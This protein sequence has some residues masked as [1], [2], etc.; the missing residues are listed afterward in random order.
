M[1]IKPFGS[2]LLIKPVD[3]K[4]YVTDSGIEVINNQ[5]KVGEIVEVSE[6]Y[7]ASYKRGDKI[8]YS[9]SAGLLQNYNKEECLWIDAR[10]LNLGGDCWGKIID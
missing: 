5:V 1:K 10:P 4:N 2:R 3:S 8:L 7:S 9:S 6:D